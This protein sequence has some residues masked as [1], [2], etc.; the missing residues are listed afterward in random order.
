MAL[1]EMLAA[2]IQIK[3]VN[4]EI[5]VKIKKSGV[6]DSIVPAHQIC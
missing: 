1:R 4:A 2:S 6:Q 3:S 5:L